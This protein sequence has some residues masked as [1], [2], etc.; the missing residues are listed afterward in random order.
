MARILKNDNFTIDN[1][2][3][4][5]YTAIVSGKKKVSEMTNGERRLRNVWQ[6]MIARCYNKNQP[7]YKHYGARGIEVCEEWRKS[8]SA[9]QVWAK[10]SGYDPDAW[11]GDCTLD[12]IDVNGNYEPS[13]CRWVNMYVQANNKRDSLK[14]E[15]RGEVHTP[16]EWFRILRVPYSPFTRFL[17]AGYTVEQALQAV[18]SGEGI[19]P[20]YKMIPWSE[21]KHPTRGG[22]RKKLYIFYKGEWKSLSE[23]QDA[24]GL[25]HKTLYAGLRHGWTID[26][27]LLAIKM[28]PEGYEPVTCRPRSLGVK[29]QK[30]RNWHT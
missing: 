15:Y 12:R 14:L 7:A 22:G 1:G 4:R 28:A 23:W 29:Y 24:L 6:G 17:H 21:V 13:N 25:Q 27:I 5:V 2:A 11:R 8:F 19:E 9:F 26:D 10:E 30:E 16:S 20:K 3:K 18:A